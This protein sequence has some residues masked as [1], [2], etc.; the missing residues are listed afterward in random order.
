MLVVDPVRRR[1]RF[2]RALVALAMGAALLLTGTTAQ[3]DDKAE[4]ERQRQ[5]NA[6]ERERLA[7]ELEGTD[8]E[9]AQT[10]LALQ[11]ATTRLP[12]AQAELAQAEGELAAAERTQQ[13][14]ADRL[15]VAEAEQA[16]LVSQLVEGTE[17]IEQTRSS[18]GE[19]ARSSYRGGTSLSTL[20]VVLD[21]S[22]SEEFVAQYAVVDTAVRTQT[23]VLDDLETI[24]AVNRNRQERQD[25]VAQRVNELKVQ[26]DEAVVAADAARAS[27]ADRTAEIQQL[28]ADQESLA[29]QLEAAKQSLSSSMA[30]AQAADDQLASRI[31]EIVAEEQRLERERQERERQE[32]ERLERERAE[33]AA[34]AAREAAANNRPAPPPPP[35][36]PAPAPPSSGGGG[37]SLIP[38]VPAPL[39]VTSPYGYRIHPL[40]GYQWMHD[41][42]D[43]RSSCGNPQVASASGTVT[44][45]RPAAGNDSHGNQVLINH[46]IIGGDS[47]ITV[48]NHL[49]RFAVSAGETVQQGQVIGYTGATGNVTGCHVHFEVWRNGATID[50]MR[51]PAF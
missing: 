5:E 47:Y 44:D 19:L 49:T 35:P 50:P 29:A 42:V 6:A 13:A 25:A 39:Y 21:A 14:V 16:E 40:A 38:P 11:D 48:Y 24:T 22:S 27:A 32:R 26:A 18:L 12:I 41:G 17:Q 37:A 43:L 15:A 33:A 3:A 36:V 8:A 1:A 20:S 51:L 46:G 7:S 30:A 9:L 45:T 23:Q 28:M 4:L 2:G 34:R 31:A 10:Y